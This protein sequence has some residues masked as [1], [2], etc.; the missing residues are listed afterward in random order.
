[1]NLTK[2]ITLKHLLINNQKMIGLQ[3][4]PDKV[5]QALI[6][7]LPKP[8][9]SSRYQMA[10]IVNSKANLDRIFNTFKGGCLDSWES[11]F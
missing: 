8:K 1:M 5:I 4:Y 6:K 11:F 2:H 3:F 10:Y 9:W 7:E